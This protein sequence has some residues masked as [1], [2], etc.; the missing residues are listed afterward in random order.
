MKQMVTTRGKD[1]LTVAMLHPEPQIIVKCTCVI[2]IK[3]VWWVLV[4]FLAE[5][6]KLCGFPLLRGCIAFENCFMGRGAGTVTA[7]ANEKKVMPDAVQ[8]T[9]AMGFQF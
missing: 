5:V 2:S 9:F 3:F 8:R 4:S 6:Q 7:L 1:N